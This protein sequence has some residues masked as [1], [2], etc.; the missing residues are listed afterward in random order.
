MSLYLKRSMTVPGGRRPWCC[1]HFRA[2]PSSAMRRE[3]GTTDT[4][5]ER[6]GRGG[7][8]RRRREKGG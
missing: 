8:G 7:R 3:G 4:S 2:C 5:P 6:A 1:C